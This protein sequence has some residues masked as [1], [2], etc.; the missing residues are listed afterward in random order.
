MEKQEKVME[1]LEMVIQDQEKKLRD[2][3]VC[4]YT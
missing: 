1:K 2:D 3:L 4:M